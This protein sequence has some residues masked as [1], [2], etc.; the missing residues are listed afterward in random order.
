MELQSNNI[1]VET[2]PLIWNIMAKEPL[3]LKS[4][5]VFQI[6]NLKWYHFYIITFNVLNMSQCAGGC[7]G[8]KDNHAEN[9]LERILQF[10]RGFEHKRT[11][12]RKNQKQKPNP[13]T[14]KR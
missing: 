4:I 2:L 9:Q 12:N 1:M 3:N 14:F 7:Q 5:S 13:L 11:A 8:E 6:N 10:R